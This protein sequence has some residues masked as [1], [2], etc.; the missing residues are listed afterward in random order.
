MDSTLTKNISNK[1]V[2]G[3]LYGLFVYN[4]IAAALAV[5]G[6]IAFLLAMPPNVGILTKLT[7]GL[8]SLIVIAVPFLNALFTYTLCDRALLVA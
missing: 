7:S 3:T 4:A 2:C 6:L 1:A 5:I 8:I